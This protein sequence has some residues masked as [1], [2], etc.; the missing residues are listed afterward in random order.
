MQVIEI[1][2]MWLGDHGYDGLYCRNTDCYCE[3][4]NLFSCA[5]ILK[6]YDCRAGVKLDCDCGR[7][8]GFHMGEKPNDN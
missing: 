5:E 2:K 1:I 8:C 7:G 6:I 3:T 4:E